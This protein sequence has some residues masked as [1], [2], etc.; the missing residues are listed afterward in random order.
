MKVLHINVN[1]ATTRLHKNMICELN[2]LSDNYIFVPIHNKA[3]I[4][5]EL[6]KKIYMIKCYNKIDRFFYYRKQNKIQCK[7]KKH[8]DVKSMDLMHAYTLMTDGNVAREISKLYNIPYIVTVRDTDLNFFFKYRK[9]LIRL[10][11]KILLD[12]NAIIFL[13]SSYKN[14]VL[15]LFNKDEKKN[16]NNKS[17][18]I[19]N[20]VDD[21]WIDKA[22]KNYKRINNESDLKL[23]YVGKITKR[24]NI[25]TL[26]K[27][28]KLMT[29]KE[30]KFKITMIGKNCNNNLMKKINNCSFIQY[31][32]FMNKE[33]LLKY[34]RDSDIF[35]MPSLSETFGLVYLEA[36]SQGTPVIYTKEEGFDKQFP[37]GVVGYSVTAASINEIY[38]SIRNI[39]ANYENISKNCIENISKFNWKA[40]SEKYYGIY[41]NICTR[42]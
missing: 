27:L 22:A 15:E 19:P 26:I 41:N 6:D 14:R 7:L 17:Y 36:M 13:S 2:N 29:E 23:L 9:D 42:R 33:Q 34:Y 10:G 8:I 16:L 38:D 20:G 12:A 31:Y 25:V 37:D 21:F 11:K 18:I 4:N 35:V 30:K 28:G 32:P 5:D 39:L 24:K 1:Y 40:I 3:I